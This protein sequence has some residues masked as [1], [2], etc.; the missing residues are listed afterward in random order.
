M[1]FILGM[2]FPQTNTCPLVVTYL[3]CCFSIINIKYLGK[4]LTSTR[5]GH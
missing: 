5:S 2:Y 3:K 4:L 1:K